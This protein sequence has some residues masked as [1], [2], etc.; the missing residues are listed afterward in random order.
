M[1]LFTEDTRFVVFMDSKNGSPTQT[2]DGRENLAPVFDHLNVYDVTTH[3]NG[4][5]TIVLDGDEASGETY[6][7]AHHLTM[8]NG[9]RTLMVASIRYLD[10]FSKQ[11]SRWFFAERLL[12]VDWTETRESNP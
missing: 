3:F 12:M 9:K 1:S 11:N 5:S 10:K 4:Q 7:L 8:A 6:C 2:I